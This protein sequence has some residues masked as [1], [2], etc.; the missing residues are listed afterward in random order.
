MKGRTKQ[1]ES[2]LNES[3]FKRM[4]HFQWNIKEKIYS[5]LRQ[6]PSVIIIQSLVFNF[7]PIFTILL[8][9]ACLQIFIVFFLFRFAHM[10][11]VSP[12][13]SSVSFLPPFSSIISFNLFFLFFR[14]LALFPFRCPSS[15]FHETCFLFLALF[16]SFFCFLVVDPLFRVAIDTNP[17]TANPLTAITNINTITFTATNTRIRNFIVL[18]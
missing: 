14:S 8:S 17:A 18:H 15:N 9:F 13:L 5:W 10:L 4:R 7:I 12:L 1:K 2:T 3:V 16:V 11:L 6:E